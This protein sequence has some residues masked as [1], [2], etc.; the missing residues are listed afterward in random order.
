[1]EKVNH[2]AYS[3]AFLFSLGKVMSQSEQRLTCAE[4]GERSGYVGLLILVQLTLTTYRPE[5][6]RGDA[7]CFYH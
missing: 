2:S 1:M 7:A 5:A 4:V 6:H 3:T